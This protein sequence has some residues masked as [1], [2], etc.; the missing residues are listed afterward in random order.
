MET[1]VEEKGRITIPAQIRRDLG[2]VKGDKLEISAKNGALILRRK[3]LVTLSDI[4]G[5]ISPLKVKLNDIEDAAGK[6]D[7][8]S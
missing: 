3:N 8:T 2:I 6:E 5:I 1:E 7:E 4:K